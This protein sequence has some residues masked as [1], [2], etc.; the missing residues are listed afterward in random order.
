MTIRHS[1]SALLTFATLICM[2]CSPQRLAGG[3]VTET[4]NAVVSGS[5]VMPGNTPAANTR[6]Q[7]IPESYDPIKS[8]PLSAANTDTTDSLGRFS[9]V[10]SA[11]ETYTLTAFRAAGYGH[12]IVK[13]ITPH[14]GDTIHVPQTLLTQSGTLSIQLPPHA[15]TMWGYIYI[16]GTTYSVPVRTLATDSIVIS[17]VPSGSTPA[18]YYATAVSPFT[19]ILLTDSIPVTGGEISKVKL[20]IRVTPLISIGMNNWPV[21][22]PVVKNNSS[23]FDISTALINTSVTSASLSAAISAHLAQC[24]TSGLRP[25]FVLQRFD[26]KSFDTIHT[27]MGDATTMQTFFT[28]YIAML[29]LVK[30]KNAILILEPFTLNFIAHQWQI[31]PSTCSP[32]KQPAKVKSSGAAQVAAY[33]DNFTGFMQAITALAKSNAPDAVVGIHLMNWTMKIDSTLPIL[34]SWSQTKQDSAAR[35]WNTYINMLGIANDIDFISIGKN[36]ADAGLAGQAFAWQ[37][38]QLNG[39]LSY[40]SSLKAITR[41]NLVG[42]YLPIGH[43]GLSNTINQYEDTFAEFF[44][45]NS[46]SFVKAGFSAMLFGKYEVNAT[47]LAASSGSGDG[48]WFVGKLAAWRQ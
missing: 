32:D 33:A 24:D 36:G 25:A 39:F 31:S 9:F 47:D 30:G 37:T 20:P 40:A 15:D 18:I 8:T 34:V 10:I 14:S 16:E 13:N 43:T 3:D 12:A 48:G 7:L 46:S 44:F 2:Q 17:H 19:R 23:L 5:L 1:V 4:G 6:V 22:W 27:Q 35:L 38:A 21:S 29:Q 41:K 28:Q 42:W 26:E 11:N 45:A